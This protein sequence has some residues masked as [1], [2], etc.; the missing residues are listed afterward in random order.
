MIL[1]MA[2]ACFWLMPAAA[3]EVEPILERMEQGDLRAAREQLDRLGNEQP[4]HPQ[5]RFLEARLLAKEGDV[6]AGIERLEAL[7]EDHPDLPAVYNNLARLYAG[8]GR[9]EKA[10]DLLEA[11]LATSETYARLYQNLSTIYVEMARQSYA[12]ALQLEG[13]NGP[14]AELNEVARLETVNG[15]ASRVGMVATADDSESE[16]V[17][18]PRRDEKSTAAITDFEMSEEE[19]AAVEAL[20][21]W[22]R[23]WTAQDVDG[24]LGYYTD[25]YS[26]DGMGRGAWREQR[27]RRLSAPDW[28]EVELR[29]A[30]AYRMRADEIV[31][32]VEQDYTSNTYSSLTLKSFTMVRENEGWRIAAEE[33]IRDIQR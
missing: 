4:D 19:R 2:S 30:R 8:E 26:P 12:Q 14:A 33:S 25:E 1:A 6:D 22:A 27:D 3:V 28:I 24:Y 7:L 20:K 10:R 31:V 21:R 23:A 32:V 17:A 18:T 16:S 15:S 9:M 5:I 29:G 11:G 13:E